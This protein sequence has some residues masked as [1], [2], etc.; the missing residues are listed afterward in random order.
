MKPLGTISIFLL[1]L[2]ASAQPQTLKTKTMKTNDFTTSILVDAPAEKVF[3]AVTDPRGW[4][5]ENIDGPTDV[6]GQTFDYH[7]KGLHECQMKVTEMKPNQKVVWHVVNNHFSFT[8][9]ENEWVGTDIIFEIET[10][11]NQTQL[12][13]THKGLVPAY[14]CYNVCHDAWTGFIQNSLYNLI[15]TGKG[16]PNP[17]EGLNSINADNI[18]K[19]DLKQ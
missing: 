14:E 8:K 19:W 13:F 1:T 7:M 17:K 10:K 11:G 2:S 5:N 3:E 16:S 9:D 15:T 6:L 12:T 4:W 18:E